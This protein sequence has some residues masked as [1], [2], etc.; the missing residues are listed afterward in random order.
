M[1]I[2]GG[3]PQLETRDKVRIGEKRATSSGSERPAS[4]DYFICSDE[5]FVRLCGDKPKRILIEFPASEAAD[6]WSD[7][8]EWWVKAS[9]RNR[10]ACY[11]KDGSASP[12]AERMEAFFSEE[13]WEEKVG[14]KHGGD[15]RFPIKCPFRE[16]P[17]MK[18]GKC[19]PMGRLTFFLHG[20]RRDTVLQIDTKSWYSC[21][22]ISRAMAAAMARKPNLVG[23]TFA[24][25]VEMRQKGQS[26]FPVLTLE[27]VSDVPVEV[28]TPADVDAAEA[29]IALGNNPTREGLA[30]YLDATRP[31]WRENEAY[32]ARIREVGADEAIKSI[33]ERAS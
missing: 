32:T 14:P 12:V 30:A 9:G 26:K 3:T 8:L 11:T 18:E 23:R 20:G 10:L 21:E 24:L 5:E 22:E 7:G 6:N 15:G 31:G 1:A 29:L 13:G 16:C 25:G 2:P 27:E 4:V 19:K 28:N 33:L 17:Q